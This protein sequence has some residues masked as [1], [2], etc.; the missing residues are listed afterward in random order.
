MTYVW[1]VLVKAD[2]Q[3]FPRNRLRFSPAIL[4]SPYTEVAFEELNRD[5]V[6]EEP[7]EI[8]T[9]YWHGAIFGHL[10]GGSGFIDYQE[11]KSTLFDILMHSVAETNMLEGL[12]KNEYHGLLLKRDLEGGIFGQEKR[13]VF[14]TFARWQSRHIISSMVR[15]YQIGPSVALFKAVMR[16][17]YPRSIIYLDKAR[18]RE[19]LVY[20]GK[21]ETPEL[22][23]Q[24][25]FLLSMFVTFDFVTHL[26]WDLH[27]GHMG[28]DETLELDEFVIY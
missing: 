6:S 18:G 28:V 8:N 16:G 11:L 9:D 12:C 2:D 3:G 1:E 26:F 20:I 25:N 22:R 27:F 15:L 14:A 4:P 13:D 19:L 21:K 5:Y 10:T 23:Q 7:I 17:A 24:V